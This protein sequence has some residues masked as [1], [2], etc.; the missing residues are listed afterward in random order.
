MNETEGKS[1]PLQIV[2]LLG[3]RITEIQ[4]TANEQRHIAVRRRAQ[5]LLHGESVRPDGGP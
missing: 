3:G 4:I 2:Q 5:L 1:L